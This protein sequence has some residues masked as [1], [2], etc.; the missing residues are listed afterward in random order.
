M[1][2]KNVK[3]Y[4]KCDI[5]CDITGIPQSDTKSSWKEKYKSCRNWINEQKIKVN[6]LVLEELSRLKNT[7]NRFSF[8]AIISF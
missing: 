1:Y 5:L 2:L 4:R 6:M 8:T 3:Y 7:P